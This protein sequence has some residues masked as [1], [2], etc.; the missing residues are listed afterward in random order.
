ME[1][2][3]YQSLLKESQQLIDLAIKG[4]KAKHKCCHCIHI[5]LDSYSNPC[6]NCDEYD[7]FEWKYADRYKLIF[8]QIIKE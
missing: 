7:K 5:D 8:G 6:R 1:Q 4:I 3:N 2:V